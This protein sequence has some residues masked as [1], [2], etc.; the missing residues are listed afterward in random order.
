MCLERQRLPCPAVGDVGSGHL[1]GKRL[2]GF[3]WAVLVATEWMF[4]AKGDRALG[5]TPGLYPVLHP[6]IKGAGIL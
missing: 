5:L 3:S 4:H 6:A 1:S 2:K